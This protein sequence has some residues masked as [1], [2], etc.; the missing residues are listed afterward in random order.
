M[1]AERMPDDADTDVTEVP[2]EPKPP[3]DGPEV[4]RDHVLKRLADTLQET[5]RIQRET[6]QILRDMR[7]EFALRREHDARFEDLF[8]RFLQS[9]RMERGEGQGT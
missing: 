7:D 4:F 2:A 5:N 3:M 1:V 6:N 9:P 8:E